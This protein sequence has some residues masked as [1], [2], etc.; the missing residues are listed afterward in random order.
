MK[1]R[2][3]RICI[4]NNCKWVGEEIKRLGQ[5]IFPQ[6]SGKGEQIQQK[7]QAK[8]KWTIDLTEFLNTVTWQFS[9]EPTTFPLPSRT[10]DTHSWK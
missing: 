4:F 8:W 7:T 1:Y 9:K 6:Y 3:K 10:E 2:K 5:V